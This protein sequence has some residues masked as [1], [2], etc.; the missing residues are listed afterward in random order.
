MGITFY[1]HTLADQ[2]QDARHLILALEDR[3]PEKLRGKLTTA[4]ELLGEVEDAMVV[5]GEGE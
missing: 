4:R 1:S 5:A 2:F 3:M